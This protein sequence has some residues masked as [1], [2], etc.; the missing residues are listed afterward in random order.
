[1]DMISLSAN[2]REATGKGVCRRLRAAGTVPAVYYAPTGENLVLA[3][4]EKSLMKAWKQVGS[5]HVFK[6]LINDAAGAVSEKPV[7]IK[8]LQVSPLKSRPSH[9]DFYG[10]DLTKEIKVTVPLE[11]V[12]KAKGVVVGG[13]LEIIRES[14]VVKCLPMNVPTKIVI[15]V[16]PME[17]NDTIQIKDVVMPEGVKAVFEDNFAV[18][19]VHMEAAEEETP[20][21]ATGKK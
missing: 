17:I 2:A 12:G 5:A 14:L 8:K 7:L 13:K 20:A 3:V 15:D 4:E 19:N 16:A 18:V 21:A 6:L 1:M 9:V 10:V 11:F